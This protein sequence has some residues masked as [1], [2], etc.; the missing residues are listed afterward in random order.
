M[1]D[2][3]KAIE[4]INKALTIDTVSY[5]FYS[6]G[7]YYS[8]EASKKYW[9]L[10]DYNKALEIDKNFGDAYYLRGLLKNELK[11]DK[12]GCEDMSKA[13]KLNV[14]L[15]QEKLKEWKLVKICR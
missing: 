9:A 2:T 10:S 3:L 12:G 6:R 1:G 8:H 14:K 15:A 13:D 11:D 5:Y 4:D 7:F